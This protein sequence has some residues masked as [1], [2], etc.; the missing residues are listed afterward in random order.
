MREIPWIQLAR[1]CKMVKSPVMTWESVII[2]HITLRHFDQEFLPQSCIIGINF[3]AF[4]SILYLNQPVWASAVRAA[5]TLAK[6]AR[7]QWHLSW[8]PGEYQYAQPC[9]FLS[10]SITD[11]SCVCVVQFRH[12]ADSCAQ[13]VQTIA[14]IFPR[15]SSC[16]GRIPWVPDSESVSSHNERKMNTH[17]TGWWE[18]H[19]VV[20]S[21]LENTKFGLITNLSWKMR[22]AETL[23]GGGSRQVRTPTKI[24]SWARI[25]FPSR[26]SVFQNFRHSSNLFRHVARCG[27]QSVLHYFL[28]IYFRSQKM[29]L[30]IFDEKNW[31]ESLASLV[32]GTPK[33]KHCWDWKLSVL[34]L[35]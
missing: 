19:I 26:K 33:K 32:V 7:L 25:I 10:V 13:V 22:V 24:Y 4:D 21:P 14:G 3:S 12:S 34:L 1:F 5:R 11:Q 2:A 35:R 8:I 20:V 27:A 18:F 16:R 17:T 23:W 15:Q 29:T 31:I 9:I 6:C 28:F 30:N